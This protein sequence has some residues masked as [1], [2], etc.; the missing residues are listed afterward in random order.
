M[1]SFSYDHVQLI[2]SLTLISTILTLNSLFFRLLHFITCI[3]IANWSA[4]KQK[5]NVNLFR[6][7]RW[8]AAAKSHLCW[9]HY[10]SQKNKNQLTIPF[11]ASP[12][13]A[14]LSELM[15]WWYDAVGGGA[16]GGGPD[17]NPWGCVL[18]WYQWLM[19]WCGCRAALRWGCPPPIPPP[20]PPPPKPPLPLSNGFIMSPIMP[21]RD[22][23]EPPLF[24]FLL[25]DDS[26]RFLVWMP[27]FFI[28]NGRFTW[29]K[30]TILRE[31]L[32]TGLEIYG[33]ETCYW[34]TNVWTE[35]AGP[36]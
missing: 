29:N 31:E 21:P 3:P 28:V 20:K 32:A 5:T 36:D 33:S 12:N 2:K 14:A 17:T 23:H 24:F 4:N 16:G 18:C 9:H 1:T 6:R 13:P 7:R 10:I 19:A 26:F 35:R 22:R 15:W 34:E 8:N 11:D 27:S 25:F 30:R